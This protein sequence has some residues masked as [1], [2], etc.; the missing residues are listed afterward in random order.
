MA[1]LVSMARLHWLRADYSWVTPRCWTNITSAKATFVQPPVSVSPT[2]PLPSPR[3]GRSMR[4]MNPGALHSESGHPTVQPC[5]Q[6]QHVPQLIGEITT[7]RLMLEPCPS[8]RLRV[9]KSLL[10]KP[11]FVEELLCPRTERTT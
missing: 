11:S 5:L 2:L 10:A 4:V 7:P 3:A 8:D 6:G 9:K 1:H